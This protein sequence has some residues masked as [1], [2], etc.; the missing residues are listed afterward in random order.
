MAANPQK[1]TNAA[2]IAILGGLSQAAA[3]WLVGLSCRSLR[4]NPG[5]PRAAGGS[6]DGQALVKWAVARADASARQARDVDGDLAGAP[7]PALERYRE[8]RALLARMDRLERENVLIPRD[9]VH[10]GLARLVTILRGLGDRLERDH[11]PA[12]RKALN[13]ALDAFKAEVESDAALSGG[14]PLAAPARALP[15]NPV[16]RAKGKKS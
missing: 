16:E 14:D 10:S 6:Y 15:E 5:V 13:E 9:K 12:A 7:S 8:E 3:A 2:Q 1:M 4:D 11:G